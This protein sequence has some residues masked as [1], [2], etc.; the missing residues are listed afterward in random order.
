MPEFSVV[1]DVIV[2]TGSGVVTVIG[3]TQINDDKIPQITTDKVC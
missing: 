2:D 1:D 3:R